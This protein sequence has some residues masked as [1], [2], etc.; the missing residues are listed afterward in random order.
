M[1]LVANMH[2]ASKQRQYYYQHRQHRLR[3]GSA[4]RRKRGRQTRL[5]RAHGRHAPPKACPSRVSNQIEACHNATGLPCVWVSP[6]FTEA[7]M[8]ELDMTV[9]W[10]NISWAGC[11]LKGRPFAGNGSPTGSHV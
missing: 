2:Q 3:V 1:V 11:S 5:R 4:V 6:R 8:T 9:E 10:L 7:D